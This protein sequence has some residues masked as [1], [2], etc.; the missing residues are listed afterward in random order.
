ML[1]TTVVHGCNRGILVFGLCL[2]KYD[3][4][5]CLYASVALLDGLNACY[6]WLVALLKS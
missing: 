1:N 3:L 2:V 6:A 4:N 5:S